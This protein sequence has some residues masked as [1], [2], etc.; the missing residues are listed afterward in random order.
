MFDETEAGKFPLAPDLAA[1]QHQLVKLELAPPRLDRDALMFAA[2]RAA[3]LQQSAMPNIRHR[4]GWL[5]PAATALMTAASLLLAA[6]LLHQSQP[7]EGAQQVAKPQE[8]VA[9]RVEVAEVRRL[10]S[11]DA[12]MLSMPRATSGYLGLR[13]LA[14]TQ[15]VAALETERLMAN[16][17]GT[18]LDAPSRPA[19][20]NARDLFNE[21]LHEGSLNTRS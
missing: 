4:A 5:W 13:H 7:R 19:P 1:L 11:D 18:G 21:L 16:G 17:R 14:L 15:G 9:E 20:A 10:R 2:G 8:A 12:A 3:G 6:T